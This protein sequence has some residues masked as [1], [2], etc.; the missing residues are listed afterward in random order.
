MCKNRLMIF[1]NLRRHCCSIL[2]LLLT[3][4][5]NISAQNQWQV[6][7]PNGN[8]QAKINLNE[9]GILF[10]SVDYVENSVNT[11]VIQS[12]ILGV[13]R[14]DE[15]FFGSLVFESIVSQ[16][17]NENY[18]MVSG[19][20]LNL[21]NHANEV[22][23]TFV[24]F[25]KKISLIF[26]AYNDGVAFRYYFPETSSTVY[27]VR[28]EYTR[29]KLASSVGKAW[30]QPYDAVPYYERRLNEYNIGQDSPNDA[31]WAF[32]A[33]FKTN[34]YWV[35]ISE[36]DVSRNN[37]VSH[38]NR[39]V[40]SG[41]YKIDPPIQDDFKPNS[42]NSAT[43]TLPWALPW[44]VLIIGKSPNVIVES[45][46]VNH[47]ATPQSPTTDVSWISSGIAL[48]SWWSDL[49][50]P[51]NYQRQREY[52]KA[53]DSLGLKHVVVDGTWDEMGETNFK[54]LIHYGDSLGVK[55]WNWYD[56]GG[57]CEQL[58]ES[59]CNFMRDRNRRR[60]E[61]AKI[62]EWGVAGIKLDF[63]MSDKQEFIKLYFDIL[64]DAAEF[65]LMVLLHGCTIPQ[66]WQRRFPNL[67][68]S[69]AVEGNEMLLFRE[70]FRYDSP[71]HNVNV[72]FTRNVLGS[73]DFT[74]GVLSIDR[75]F[76]NTTTAHE[77]ALLSVFETGFTTLADRYQ[78][79]LQLPAIAKEIIGKVPVAWDEIKFIEGIPDDYIVLARRKGDA[80]YVSGINGKNSQRNITI[81]PTF[82]QTGN[83]QKQ[84]LTDGAD[85][86]Q[87]S[88][89]QENF[90]SNGQ[91]PI[92]MLPYGGFTVV[93]ETKCPNALNIVQSINAPTVPYT[94]HEIQA[95]NIV[96]AG[97]NTVYSANKFVQLNA[98]FSAQTGS[99]FKAEI[100]GCVD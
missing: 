52:V 31:G 22:N 41:D 3:F 58:N 11:Q 2:L 17:I 50:S 30:M 9:F 95:S 81:T 59:D 36:S 92:T 67:L 5:L 28:N 75:V 77:L 34:N 15:S 97:G 80:W 43:S 63:F 76:H 46:L 20:Q 74:P 19:K 6:T 24:K 7:S 96:G 18:S 49:G 23:I 56:A 64:E 79:Y 39:Y 44:R 84:I 27:T 16:T 37:Y 87:I 29:V 26:R 69:E 57:L 62:H 93:L 14:A 8:I 88:V 90:Q 82:L 51:T 66:G 13:E 72:A 91:I 54:N 99:V 21:Q 32:P 55:I 1:M 73:I 94:A 98:G 86:R 71:H 10:Y 40:G 48:W 85:A 38:I 4:A 83:Y 100:G 68:S 47:L 42:P 25:G 78:S 53:A 60:A 12:S 45:S 70:E 65:K 89:N 33:L 61:F 35:L